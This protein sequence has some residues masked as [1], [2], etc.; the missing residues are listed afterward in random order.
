M[1]SDI[2]IQFDTK[3]HS[4]MCQRHNLPY[5]SYSPHGTWT[6]HQAKS[7]AQESTWHQQSIDTPYQKDPW[8]S[9]PIHRCYRLWAP[10]SNYRVDRGLSQPIPSEFVLRCCWSSTWDNLVRFVT[11]RVDSS[12]VHSIQ[13]NDRL[14]LFEIYGRWT[15]PKD[16][17]HLL[18]DIIHPNTMCITIDR[19]HET[20]NMVCVSFSGLLSYILLHVSSLDWKRLSLC[21]TPVPQGSDKL[22]STQPYD[23][24]Q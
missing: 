6:N 5:D 24:V 18:F 15:G 16:S 19:M 9:R 7:I 2:N 23:T 3:W 17:H 20:L 1:L 22:R 13:G 10:P 12:D 21:D 4:P 11:R 14:L 8:S